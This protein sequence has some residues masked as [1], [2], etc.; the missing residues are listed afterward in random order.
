MLGSVIPVPI[1]TAVAQTVIKMEKSVSETDKMVVN[2]IFPPAPP[3]QQ[4]NQEETP[5]PPQLPPEG[6]AVEAVVEQRPH[7]P[8]PQPPPPNVSPIPAT[9]IGEPVNMPV[10][11]H[12]PPQASPV[13]PKAGAATAAT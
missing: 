7:Q 5:P 10:S 1:Q 3:P 12:P 2:V 8:Q 6:Q 9:L 13:P 4:K 11:V